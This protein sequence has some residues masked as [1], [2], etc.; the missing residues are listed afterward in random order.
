MVGL[1][2]LA[3]RELSVRDRVAQVG[4]L[5][6][7]RTRKLR[8]SGVYAEAAAIHAAYVGL[9]KP[10]SSNG[11]ALKRAVFLGWYQDAEPACLTGVAD[12]DENQVG[13]ALELLDLIVAA[14]GL[15]AELAAMLGWY[16]MVADWHFTRG[17]RSPAALRRY[18]SAL[19]VDAWRKHSFSESNLDAR[20]LMGAYWASVQRR[21][22]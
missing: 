6:E 13:S 14:D 12:L 20:G 4:G 5:V 16:W 8:E 11:E 17:S 2:D 9:A 22:G 21:H 19:E 15:D 10:P 7:D 18:L 3:R 1:E